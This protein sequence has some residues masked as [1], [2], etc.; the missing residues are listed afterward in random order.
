ME[1]HKTNWAL[2]SAYAGTFIVNFSNNRPPVLHESQIIVENVLVN[3]SENGILTIEGSKVCFYYENKYSKN[4]Q[5]LEKILEKIVEPKIYIIGL[6]K[7]REL[8][9]PGWYELKQRKP[10]SVR[11][12]NWRLFIN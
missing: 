4:W 9:E 1:S 12:T 5:P 2:L 3:I 6:F 10:Y 7:K 8:L 11:T